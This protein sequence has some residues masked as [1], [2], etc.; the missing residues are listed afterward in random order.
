MTSWIYL[1]SR[2]TPEFLLFEALLIFI[3]TGFFSMLWFIHRRH[4]GVISEHLPAGVFKHYLNEVMRNAQTIQGQLF[5]DIS[6]MEGAGWTTPTVTVTSQTDSALLQKLS[7]L[8]AQL[9]E[10]EKSVQVLI[11][12]KQKIERELITAKTAYQKSA[13]SES[14]ALDNTELFQLREKVQTLEDR[15][16]EYSVIE[17]DLANLKRLQQEN[18]QLKQ[19][20]ETKNISISQP[21]SQEP[22]SQ[23]PQSQE[24]SKTQTASVPTLAPTPAPQ[25]PAPSE[26]AIPPSSSDASFENLVDQVEQSL[27]KE[28]EPLP[29]KP[30]PPQAAAAASPKAAPAE[31]DSAQDEKTD[32]ELVAEFEKMLKS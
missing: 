15:L 7:V 27:Q 20:L 22:H 23:E 12:E 11:L 5:G 28:E 13:S 2:F 16:A 8:E 17:D 10:K 24:I 18:T 26:A 21:Q 6:S 29:V 9:V 1:F 31:T 3:L 32:S 30:P 14:P 4:F 25:P 19:L